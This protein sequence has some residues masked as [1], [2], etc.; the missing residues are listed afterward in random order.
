VTIGYRSPRC[1]RFAPN[2]FVPVA[3]M[4]SRSGPTDS[5]PGTTAH[6]PA[7]HR[8]SASW[9]AVWREKDR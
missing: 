3:A 7:G 8:Q 9:P 1:D 4:T 2:V 6:D 5:S